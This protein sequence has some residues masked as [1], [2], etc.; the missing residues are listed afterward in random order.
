[1]FSANK[2]RYAGMKYRRCGNS[3]I[4]LPELSLGLWQ[5]FSEKDDYEKCK[6]IIT[7]AFDR[8][9]THFD[10][11]NNYGGGS[12]ETVFGRILKTELSAYRDEMI[13]STKAGYRMWDGP[14]GDGGS[15]KYLTASLDQS[16]RRLGIDYVDIFY[17]HRPD[18][19]TS[20][21]ET[22]EALASAVQT[23]KALYVGISNY[24]P[25]MAKKAIDIL[26]NMK[27]R[28][29]IGQSKYS[30]LDRTPENGLLKVLDSRHVGM[31]AFQSLCQ[32]LLT[33]R[34]LN[35][36]PADSRI[37]QG[38]GSILRE[39]VTDSLVAKLQALAAIA[40]RRGQT[41]AQM[42]IAWVLQDSRVSSV[43]VGAS[44]CLQLE[45][46]L[47]ALDCHSFSFDDLDDI[48][49]ILQ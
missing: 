19:D 39:D 42:A 10:L 43:I 5:H 2:N 49:K 47:A 41:L 3:G 7:Y 34:Y 25:E 17:S 48:D 13:I 11:A 6:S 44:S 37:L 36:I 31:V 46:S 33:D 45:D 35:G 1:M 20:L 38:K 28:C 12:S 22:M 24:P 40:K 8:G 4:L 21:E 23:G 18:P 27:V 26:A 30:M 9:I 15:R 14:Y 32:G 16:L 29:F